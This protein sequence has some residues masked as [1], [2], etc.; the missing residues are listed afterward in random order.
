MDTILTAIL[1]VLL[2]PFTLLGSWLVVQPQ[3]E[4]VLLRW[5]KFARLVQQ[6]GLH[7]AV[8][9]GRRAIRISTK[10]QAIEV[11]RTVVA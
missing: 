7:W 5:G 3:Q 9:W 11:H 6:P 4:I 1:S 8:L 2:F 10:Q